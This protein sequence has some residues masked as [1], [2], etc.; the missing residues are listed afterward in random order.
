MKNLYLLLFTF[1]SAG[2]IFATTY[3]AAPNASGN[4][5]SWSTPGDLQSLIN[6]AVI[7]DQIW[8]LQ[9]TYTPGN[10]RT[11]SFSMKNGISIYGSFYGFES[12]LSDRVL[13][14]GLSSILS[15]EIGLAGTSDNCYHVLHNTGLDNSA[16]LDGFII[17]GANDDRSP[18]LSEGLG[19]G[20]F[21]QGSGNGNECSQ[22]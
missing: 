13:L 12:Q 5:S 21:N 22:Q 3:Y 7:G 1:L 20:M 4:G 6:N 17:Q 15:G 2:E 19:G 18:T 9:G 11:S 8:A 10:N 14:S 16:I